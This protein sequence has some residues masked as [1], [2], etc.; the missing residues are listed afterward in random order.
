MC[1]NVRFLLSAEAQGKTK[2]C[3]CV[4]MCIVLRPAPHSTHNLHTSKHHHSTIPLPTHTPTHT[5]THTHSAVNAGST[6]WTP[7]FVTTHGPPRKR[8]PSCVPMARW[9]ASGWKSRSSCRGGQTMPSRTI[10]TVRC[11]GWRSSMTVHR[12]KW[13]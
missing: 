2:G 3:V 10:G 1:T 5:H 13:I 7:T 8:P 9:V 11:G 4:S 6:S 12:G